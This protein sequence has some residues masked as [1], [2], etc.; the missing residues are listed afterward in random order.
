M[1]LS[2]LLLISSLNLGE[3]TY[4]PKDGDRSLAVVGPPLV[5][6]VGELVN[7]YLP[8]ELSFISLWDGSLEGEMFTSSQ[9]LK[10]PRSAVGTYRIFVV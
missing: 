7:C 10:T 9:H 3:I 8:P 2:A 4:L 5:S 1:T 6:I